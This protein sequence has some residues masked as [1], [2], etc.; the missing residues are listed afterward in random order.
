M[1]LWDWRAGSA[2]EKLAA[3]PEDRG[4]VPST[5]VEPLTAAY[6]PSSRGLMASWPSEHTGNTYT[7]R[8][9]NVHINKS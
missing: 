7:Y 8:H 5:Y 3:L 4:S 6:N 1:S 2:I 9:T